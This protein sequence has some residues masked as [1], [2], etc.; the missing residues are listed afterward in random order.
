MFR[1][2]RRFVNK[3]TGKNAVIFFIVI[4][5]CCVVAICLGIYSQYFYRYSAT[6][7]LMLGIHI[8][9]KK[10]AQE[11][12]Q[13]KTEFDNLFSNKLYIYGNEK[14]DVNKITNGKS[15]VYTNYT[16]ENEDENYYYVKIDV[17]TLNINN[18][19]AKKIN[20]EIKL[21]YY[22]EANNIMRTAK[23]Y[24]IYKVSY[25]AYVNKG[26]LSIAIKETLKSGNKAE[27][28]K[29]KTY[30]YS[31]PDEKEITLN[32]LIELKGIS[33]KEVQDN[34]DTTIEN[35]Y[36]NA[37]AIEQEY[38]ST[39]KRDLKNS[40]YK[41]DNAKTYFLTNDGYV[42]IIYAYGE[43]ANTNEIDIVIF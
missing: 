43:Y 6:D 22:D 29:I 12:A 3:L 40:I 42:Y 41:V 32:D 38:G 9:S 35:A 39:Y 7:P 27:T 36:N 23:N 1:A 31:I 37:L 24:T 33:K 20:E 4:F 25:V 2:L 21:N 16:I 8:G 11:Y 14:V 34:I 18:D 30:N 10:S 17:P 15:I 19:V 13:L 28:V 5:L 26:A